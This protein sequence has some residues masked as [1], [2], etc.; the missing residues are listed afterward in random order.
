L[1]INS[2][3]YVQNYIFDD[4]RKF[5]NES[6][7]K[8]ERKSLEKPRKSV[9]SEDLRRNKDLEGQ[10]A[11]SESSKENGLGKPENQKWGK[12]FKIRTKK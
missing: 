10:E 3:Y 7:W 9:Q 8:G 11:K 5:R 4:K 1:S 2:K 12:G 6:K